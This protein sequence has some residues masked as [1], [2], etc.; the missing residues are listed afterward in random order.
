M[1][2]SDELFAETMR[3][4]AAPKAPTQR[5]R[6]WQHPQG[7]RFLVQW[8]NAVLLRYL[9]RLF[10][11]GLPKSEYRRKAQI[12]DAARSVVRNIEE[13][14]KRSNTATYTEF[15]GFSQGSLEEVKGDI[16][17]LTEDGFLFSKSGSSLRSIGLD[18]GSFNKSLHPRGKLEEDKGGYSPQ[19][20]SNSSLQETKGDYRNG[21]KPSES[22]SVFQYRPITV[23][24][25]PLSKVLA[26]DL[27]YEIFIELIN[28]TDYLLRVLV[29]S[30]E[31]KLAQN[32]MAYKIEQAR[33]RDNIKGR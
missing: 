33:I 25:F 6:V 28:K 12:D 27:T 32:Q 16:R 20:S 19:E 18:L 7:Y 13:G 8:S 17:E 9:V 15:I 31:K 30:L 3:E 21:K 26:T 23:I 24:Y 2:I 10:T 14:Y 22:D 11:L 29:E 1:S 4:L 5:S